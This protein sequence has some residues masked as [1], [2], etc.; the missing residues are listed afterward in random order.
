MNRAADEKLRQAVR[1]WLKAS[2]AA[3]ASLHVDGAVFVRVGTVAQLRE[4]TPRAELGAD[5]AALRQV[6]ERDL[7][8]MW[9]RLT[10]ETPELEEA[11]RGAV[12]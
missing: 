3:G 4:V 11:L 9:G 1:E 7:R 2:P 10:I 12:K 5:L 8:D 6:F